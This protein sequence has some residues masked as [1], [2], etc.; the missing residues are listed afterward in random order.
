ML[1]FK[2]ILFETFRQLH[3]F[4]S[5]LSSTFKQLEKKFNAEHFSDAFDYFINFA[6]QSCID[7]TWCFS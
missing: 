4:D 7:K 3:C 5:T 2:T 1:C 6:H